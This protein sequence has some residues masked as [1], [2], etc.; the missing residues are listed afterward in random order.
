MARQEMK[1]QSRGG[2]REALPVPRSSFFLSSTKGHGAGSVFQHETR[3]GEERRKKGE[4]EAKR[5]RETERDFHSFLKAS[6]K[7]GQ[8]GLKAESCGFSPSQDPLS[9]DKPHLNP[10][11]PPPGERTGRKHGSA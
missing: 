1:E 6:L 11:T 5:K 4:R 10:A 9:A 2:S 7:P 8:P 3:G